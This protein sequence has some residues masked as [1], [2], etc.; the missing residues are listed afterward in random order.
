M[1]WAS[2]SGMG[3]ASE[4]RLQNSNILFIMSSF[5]N[6]SSLQ[7]ISSSEDVCW[8]AQ[9]SQLQLTKGH[10]LRHLRTAVVA[11]S[12]LSG[13]PASAPSARIG[14]IYPVYAF[15]FRLLVPPFS[16]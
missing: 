5:V 8:H 6:Q 11:S 13:V 7:I 3:N 10:H 1:Q 9:P 15:F 4:I 16:F 14:W 12:V 2:N